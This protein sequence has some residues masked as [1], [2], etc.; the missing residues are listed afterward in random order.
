MTP[1]LKARVLSTL[2]EQLKEAQGSVNDLKM[3]LKPRYAEVERLK[4]LIA[5]WEAGEGEVPAE[6]PEGEK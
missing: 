5:T 1:E 2:K 6:K 4:T 3:M